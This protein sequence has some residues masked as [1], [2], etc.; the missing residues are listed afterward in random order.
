MPKS[1]VDKVLSKVFSKLTT[2][3]NAKDIEL[4]ENGKNI[5]LRRYALKDSKG[6]TAETVKDAFYRVASHI[7]DGETTKE[8]KKLYTKHFYNFMAEKRF[9]P[10]TPTWSGSKTPL[11]QLAACFV[12]PIEDDMGSIR[13]G[14]FDTLKS[15]VLIQQTGGGNGFSFSR[16]RPKGDRVS[17]SNGVAS[18][19]ISFLAA[20]DSAFGHIAQ[21]GTRRGANMA[22]LR[23][24]HPDIHLFIKCKSNEGEVSN[25]NIS[26]GITDKFMEAVKND[27]DFDLVNPRDKSVWETVKARDLFNEIVSHSYKNGEPGMLFLDAANRDNPVPEQYTLEATNPCG[28]QWLGPYENCCL[29]HVNI[30]ASVI[31]NKLDWEHLRQ[32]VVLGV[33]FLD[34]VVTQNKY[35]A[36]VP[37]LKEAALKNRRIGLGFM[38]LADA[39]YIL[40]IRYGSEESLDF[41]S[42]V[43]EFIRYHAMLAS[44]ALAGEK[45]SFPGIKKSIYDYDKDKLKWKIPT[46]LVKHK[47]IWGR[48]DLDWQ[49]VLEALGKNGIRNSTQMTVAPT[50]TTAT[51]YGLEGYGC[52]PVFALA[53]FR[54]V[55]QSA[56]GDKNL[57]LSYVSPIFKDAIE[58][59]KLSEEVKSEIIKVALN[60]GSIQSLKIAPDELKKVFVVS[61][62]IKPEEHVWMQAV[63]QRF[64]DNSISKTCN[65]PE[66]ATEEDV[67]KA[68]LMAWELGCKGLT[69]YVTGSRNEVVLETKSTQDAKTESAEAPVTE[70]DVV[71]SSK[72]PRPK[73]V[74]GRTH[75]ISTP[76]GKAFVTVNRN[77]ETGQRPFEVF[78]TLGKSGS[79][80]AAFA[81]A[82]GRL[83]S[84]W[85]RSASSPD[86]ALEEIAYQLKGIGGFTS[87]GFGF[88]RVSSIPDAVSKILRDE[89]EYTKKLKESNGLMVLE[90]AGYEANQSSLFQSGNRDVKTSMNSDDHNVEVTVPALHNASMCPE[91]NNMT[92][93]ETEGCIKCNF[94]GYSRC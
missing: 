66:T 75:E 32:T 30:K 23:V 35:V 54:N 16:L 29:G 90:S 18:G 50:G 49:L 60:S 45:G 27:S 36:S 79:D 64:I 22:V 34:N 38:G 76:F 51:V 44:I 73:V 55:Y 89:I 63:I 20:Y 17:K 1:S 42:Q 24:D 61:S 19:P 70:L 68:Y 52:E 78:V 74:I 85:L 8:L 87:I 57:Q 80:T 41:A 93:L 65:F 12:L 92:L 46:S 26:V 43:S 4:D 48:P 2:V 94:C 13:G 40:G 71:T 3:K 28:E 47:K 39:M 5:F 82:L 7:G 91:C 72:R 56:G 6:Q 58:K 33:R 59:L 86:H 62:D 14:I 53:Y 10:N 15:G 25:F 77:G 84:G 83:I 11:G 69:V 88:S 31:N 81:E 9:V 67:R 37:E 21:G